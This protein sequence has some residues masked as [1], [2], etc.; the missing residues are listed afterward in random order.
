MSIHQGG[1][2]GFAV[3]DAAGGVAGMLAVDFG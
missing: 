3:I 2:K 1:H